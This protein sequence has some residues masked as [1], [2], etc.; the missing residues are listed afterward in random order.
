VLQEGKPGYI[1]ETI[2]IFYENEEELYREQLGRDYY[3]P[4]PEIYAVGVLPEG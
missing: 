2:R 1:A 4:T 3:A